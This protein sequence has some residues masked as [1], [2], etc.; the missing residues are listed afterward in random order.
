MTDVIPPQV[1]GLTQLPA[2]GGL[3]DQMLSTFRVTVSEPL[4]AAT[5]NPPEYAQYGGHTYWMASSRRWD[6]ALVYAQ[7]SGGELVTIN[8]AAEQDW[9][10]RTFGRQSFWLGL[11]DVATE[12]TWVWSDG[13]PVS[14]T[15]WASG[16]P[17]S[18]QN[19]DAAYFL[20]TDGTW[21]DYGVG[22]SLP[23]PGGV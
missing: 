14:Y 13:Q 8:N 18:G 15:N 19:Y 23:V 12:G 20:A 9:L 5:A 17:N 1:T 7:L 2:D 21:Y 3:T 11:N 16:E 4:D 22:S 6:D 10:L